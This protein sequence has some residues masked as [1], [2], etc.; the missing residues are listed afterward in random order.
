MAV[1]MGM[2]KRFPGFINCRVRASDRPVHPV[3]AELR[4]RRRYL[5]VPQD[6]LAAVIGVSQWTLCKWELGSEMPIGTNLIAWANALGFDLA[7][8][9]V[10]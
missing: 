1:V 2:V 4:E 7:L 5:G 3:I 9:E 6:A 8:R 10:G